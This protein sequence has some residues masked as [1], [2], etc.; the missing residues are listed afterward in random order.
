MAV[1]DFPTPTNG[2]TYTANGITYVYDGDKWTANGDDVFVP[3]SG[4]AMSGSVTVPERTVTTSFDLSEGPYWTCG[5]IDIPNPTNGVA[6]MT[7]QILLTAAP[8]SWGNAFKFP[9]G[10][11]N[12]QA[13]PHAYLAL[14]PYFVPNSGVIL[15]GNVICY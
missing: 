2:A 10:V 15:L 3:E 4:G 7:G 1:L 8:N 12:V 6:G 5:A 13:T 11:G 9:G 14:V